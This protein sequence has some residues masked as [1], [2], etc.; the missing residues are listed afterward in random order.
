MGSA[1]VAAVGVV[2]AAVGV[3][4]KTSAVL[5]VGT[6]LVGVGLAGLVIGGAIWWYSR[7]NNGRPS[8]ITSP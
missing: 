4:T 2:G 6:V 5:T 3:A 8:Q 1:A 7:R